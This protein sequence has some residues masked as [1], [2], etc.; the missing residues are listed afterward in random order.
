ME[1]LLVSLLGFSLII[2]LGFLAEALFDK[3][4]IPDVLILFLIGIFVGP[5]MNW[6]RPESFA[7]I[8]PIFVSLALMLILFEGSINLKITD[9]LKG[10]FPGARLSST[11]FFASVLVVT[12]IMMIFGY[13]MY[14]G[15][16]LGTIVGGTSSAVVIPMIKLLKLDTATSSI[17]TLESTL[18]DVLC[19]TGAITVTEILKLHDFNFLNTL[20]S[21]ISVFLIAIAIGM[22]CGGIWL[23]VRYK[24]P[25]IKKAYM[26]S[27]AYIIFIYVF[28]ELLNSNG[29]IA[30]LAFGIF[31]GN[32]KQIFSYL[33][34]ES[35]YHLDASEKIFYSEISF[36]LKVFFFVYLGIII[37]F[38]NMY[39]FLIGFIITVAVAVVRPFI[40]N[41]AVKNGGELTKE[42]I[43]M[44]IMTPK[45]LAAA[46]LVQVTLKSPFFQ[47]MPLAHDLSVITLSVILFSILLTSGLVFYY[48]K[49]VFSNQYV[50]NAKK[51]KS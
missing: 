42:K 36:F 5:V 32:I 40:V 39:L 31:L 16:L 4:H 26:L 14:L 29:A 2:M 50:K 51:S 49:F 45:G 37:N 15:I 48:E 6:S 20:T 34:Q 41:L 24:F 28:T 43:V 8:E 38:Q 27:I 7:S 35:E 10:A 21:L 47:S 23:Y 11:F 22:I 33:D 9:F 13:P 19:I 18:T 46:V 25:Q 44:S 12:G 1:P 3:T 17:L 30:V